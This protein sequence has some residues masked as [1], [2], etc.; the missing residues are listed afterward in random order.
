MIYKRF[1]E[2]DILHNSLEANPEVK[3]TIANKNIYI[4]NYIPTAED[5]RSSKENGTP[6]SVNSISLPLFLTGSV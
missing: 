2:G 6:L 5:V 1:E 3:I 4:K